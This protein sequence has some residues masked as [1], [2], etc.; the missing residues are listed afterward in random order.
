MCSSDR[1]VSAGVPLAVLEHVAGAPVVLLEPGRK[2]FDGLAALPG[3]VRRL[4]IGKQSKPFSLN[5][6]PSHV[7]E[8]ELDVPE[9]AAF[10]ALPRLRTLGWTR[11]R[12]AGAAFIRAQPALFEL[13]LRNPTIAALPASESLERLILFA[14]TKLATLAGIEGLPSLRFLRIDSPKSMARLGSLAAAK[15]VDTLILI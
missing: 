6:L 14:P 9:I 15:R 8:L 3:S 2:S 11:M 7:E 13:A 4:S 5:E 10:K 1:Q 12:D